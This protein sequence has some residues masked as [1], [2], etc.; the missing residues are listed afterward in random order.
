MRKRSDKGLI[1]REKRS[2]Q[3]LIIREKSSDTSLM[4]RKL[5]EV[6][7][8]IQALIDELAKEP[9]PFEAELLRLCKKENRFE[10]EYYYVQKGSS[11]AFIVVYKMKLNI[12]TY[13]KMDLSLRTSVIGY[14][15]SLSEPGFITNDP[16]LVLE[17]AKTLKGPVLIL[18]TK[19]HR[20]HKDFALGQTLPTCV[21]QN[22]F[23]TEDEYLCALRSHY[24][25]RIKL[26]IKACSHLTVKEITDDSIDVYQLYLNT[27]NKSD[28]KLEKLEKGFFD[29]VDATKIV[30]QKEDKPIGF[31]LLRKAE[32]KL[33]FMLCGMDYSE[34]TTDLY[35]YMLFHIIRYGIKHGCKTIDFGQTSEETKLKFGAA[36]EERY[37]YAHHSN[38]II[39]FLVKHGRYLLEYRYAFPDFCVFKR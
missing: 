35:Y 9:F 25:R 16:N 5:S 33:I 10:Q 18:N 22:R 28:Y 31:V 12:F 8:D 29:K 27:Y 2:D 32:D 36:L 23:K 26:A 1:I 15:C 11:K 17:F 7:E 34:D 14:P 21:F 37:F 6:P 20:P 38:R 39:N 4:V 30:F 24:R 13:G 19:E 3:D